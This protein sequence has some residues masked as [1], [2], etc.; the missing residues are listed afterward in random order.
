LDRSPAE[1]AKLH[2]ERYLESIRSGGGIAWVPGAQQLVDELRAQELK[3][4]VVSSSTRE[5]VKTVLGHLA[6]TGCFHATVAGDEVAHGK[7]HPEPFL[8]AAAMLGF[9]PECCAVIEDS[10]NGVLAAKAA[11]MKCVGYLNPHSG[12][13]DLSGADWIVDNLHRVD[14]KSLR[15]RGCFSEGS[16]VSESEIPNPKSEIRNNQKK[17]P[18]S[19]SQR[20]QELKTKA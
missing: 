7:P 13:Q 6:I 5:I 2:Q 1:L 12:E 20:R 3:L 19:K 18:N 14:T 15:V 11:G 16:T 17:T 8:R 10:A 4:A 9:P